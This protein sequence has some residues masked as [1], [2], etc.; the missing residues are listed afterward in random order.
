MN[1]SWNSFGHFPNSLYFYEQEYYH[2]FRYI[3]A[4]GYWS[5]KSTGMPYNQ[6]S[7]HIVFDGKVWCLMDKILTYM[8]IPSEYCFWHKTRKMYLL[9]K[10]PCLCSY[11]VT[12]FW[13]RSF[14]SDRLGHFSGLCCPG[15]NLDCFIG[16]WQ[17]TR[18][19]FKHRQAF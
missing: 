18:R 16:S 10:K 9:K 15:E 19:R 14:S 2:I 11:N 17:R 3:N 1:T 4:W 7:K 13:R 8:V 6:R 12:V 5:T